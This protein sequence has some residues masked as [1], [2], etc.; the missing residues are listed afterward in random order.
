MVTDAQARKLMDEMSKHGRLGVA[1]QRAGMHRNT[2]RRYVELGKRGP[3]GEAPCRQMASI[4]SLP[5][6]T[7]TSYSWPRSKSVSSIHLPL[8]RR[9]G[10]RWPSRQRPQ[11]VPPPAAPA[12]TPDPDTTTDCQLLYVR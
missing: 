9:S 2:G 3:V 10:S 4:V 6:W 11:T 1:A 8:I 12:S 5:G 7:A